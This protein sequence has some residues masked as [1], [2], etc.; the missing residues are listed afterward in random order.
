MPKHLLYR[1]EVR[2][3]LE[4]V[5]GE[6]VAQRVV[7]HAL[8]ETGAEHG[9]T[10]DFLDGVFVHVMAAQGTLVRSDAGCH[11]LCQCLL[12]VGISQRVP[13]GKPWING[14]PV[15]CCLGGSS[16]YQLELDHFKSIARDTRRAANWILVDVI[17]RCFDRIG[18]V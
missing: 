16:R 10:H 12:C 4:Q 11:W 17:D 9:A 1:A 8:G 13:I 2:S 7:A 18:R 15:T 14:S 3:A 5:R 6:A